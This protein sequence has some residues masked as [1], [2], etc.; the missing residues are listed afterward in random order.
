M[1]LSLT[2]LIPRNPLAL[3]KS[4]EAGDVSLVS[5]TSVKILKWRPFKGG[6]RKR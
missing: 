6:E 4:A 3:C 1:V 2:F 5:V